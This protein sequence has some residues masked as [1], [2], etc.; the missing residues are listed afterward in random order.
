MTNMG[1]KPMTCSGILSGEPILAD[2][3]NKQISKVGVFVDSSN[4]RSP[5]FSGNAVCNDRDSD[6]S[7]VYP[8]GRDRVCGN[9]SQVGNDLIGE[10]FVWLR[11]AD[12]D[13]VIVHGSSFVNDGC[14]R[15]SILSALELPPVSGE[16]Q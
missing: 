6:V 13:E 11:H 2:F 12:Q 4:R 14:V 5:Y 10:P 16:S 9:A 7:R 1:S 3:H 15:T 8:E